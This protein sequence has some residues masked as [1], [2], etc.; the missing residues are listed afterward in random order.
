MDTGH[1]NIAQDQLG[2]V[3][4]YAPADA[5]GLWI[6][7]AVAN[8]LNAKGNEPMRS[9]FVTGLF[10]GRGIYSY[11]SGAS[12]RRL[13]EEYRAK[14]DA[15]DDN[16]YSRFAGALRELADRYERE[17]EREAARDRYEV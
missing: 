16:A 5:D 15:L 10:N 14:A 4:I 11:S 2:H 17:A 3:L 12:E 1:W 13:A 6:H 8:A 7:R 9:G